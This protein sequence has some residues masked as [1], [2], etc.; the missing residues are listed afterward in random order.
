LILSANSTA[1]QEYNK[2]WRKNNPD[3]AKAHRRKSDLKRR[4]NLTYDEYKQMFISQNNC[5]KICGKDSPGTKL[6][7][8]IDH[9]HSTNRVRGVLCHQCNNILGKVK[10]SIP[11]LEKF[12]QYLKDSYDFKC[13]QY[14]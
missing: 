9:D 14:T 6:G 7:W 8:H 3:R 5:C 11:Y 1:K 12:I 13:Q 10:D 2:Q 4:Y